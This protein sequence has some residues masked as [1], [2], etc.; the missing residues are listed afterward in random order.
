M[1]PRW[2]NLTKRLEIAKALKHSSNPNEIVLDLFGGS[3]STL[4]ACSADGGAKPVR[5]VGSGNGRDVGSR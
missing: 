2:S 3:G 1:F 5:Y 4:I